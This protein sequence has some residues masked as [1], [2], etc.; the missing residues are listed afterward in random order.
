VLGLTTDT[1]SSG[2]PDCGANWMSSLKQLNKSAAQNVDQV[3]IISWNDYDAG[4]QIE[5]GV[6]GCVAIT[7]M[8]TD[9][10]VAWNSAGN[11]ETIDHYTIYASTDGV[12]FTAVGDAA[13]TA[14]GFDLSALNTTDTQATVVVQ[15]VGKSSF[16]NKT[17]SPVTYNPNSR[18][19]APQ[20]SVSPSSGTYP[21]TVS[22]TVST[23]RAASSTFIDFGDGTTANTASASHTYKK[24]G[25]FT[26]TGTVTDTTGYTSSSTK[27]V[28][29]SAP[30]ANQAPEAKLAVTPTSGTAPL[31]VTAST[32]GS[33]DPDGTIASVVI[34][35][36]D[37]TRSN[38]AS[39]SHTYST[40]G[41]YTVIATV[42][43]NGGLSASA[44]ST[45]TAAAP[46]NQAP[47]AKLSV[48]PTTGTAPLAVT[49]STAGSSDPDGTIASVVIDFGDG[50][51][52]NTASASHTYSAAGTFTIT[53]TVTD[54]GGL[55]AAATS[56]V[57]AAAPANQAPVAKLAVTPTSG[58]APLAVTASTSG[59]S[60]PDGTIASVVIDFGDGTKANTASASH[61]YSTAGTYTVKA[62][63]TDNGGLSASA[64]S[65]VVASAPPVNQAPVA[66][67]AVTP[68]SGTAP[69]AVTASTSGSSDPDGTIASV[70][71]DFGDGTK[72]NSASAS[73]TYSAAGTYTVTATVTDN[74]GLSSNASTVVTATGSVPSL[75]ISVTPS[76]GTGYS[77]EYVYPGATRSFF[78]RVTGSSN[79]LVNWTASCGTPSSS[80]GA[81][82]F[83]WTAPSTAGD[84]T[85]TAT[86][87]A[88]GSKVAS[89]TVT[90]MSE[91]IS[92][93]IMPFYLVLYKGQ[94]SDL[95]SMVS[96]ASTANSDVTW[97]I[98][99]PS[100][101]TIVGN[102][103]DRDLGWSSTVAG[104]YT[105]KATSTR[106]TSK[107]AT[108]TIIVTGNAMPYQATAN[109]TQPVDCT[110]T[111]SGRCVDIGKSGS[112]YNTIGSWFSAGNTLAAGDTLRIW[113]KGTAYN[114]QLLISGVFSATQ[115]ARICG[116]PD[117]NGNL[118]EIN[119][120]NAS[121]ANPSDA[122]W[123]PGQ[124]TMQQ[125]GLVVVRNTSY[126]PA[127]APQYILIE[128]LK[129]NQAQA[130]DS[131]KAIGTGTIT[132][133]YAGTGATCVRVQ[134][135]YDVVIRGN[136]IAKCGA[137]GI[138]S[139]A[140]TPEG[141]M[142]RRLTIEGNYLHDNATANN[143]SMHNAYIQSDGAVIQFNYFGHA[144]AGSTG[145][146]LK[147][148]S[149]GLYV[150]YN[151][152]LSE[153]RLMDFVEPQ[154]PGNYFYTYV[155]WPYHLSTDPAD[156]TTLGTVASTEE[157]LWNVYSYG[158]TMWTGDG[159]CQNCIHY[160]WD[161]LPS[162]AQGGTLWLY[163]NTIQSA[164]TSSTYGWTLWD[165]GKNDDA[166]PRPTFPHAQ[167]VNNLIYRNPVP[168]SG[169]AP[170]FDWAATT[171]AF[172]TFGKNWIDP[173]WG[174]GNSSP[175]Y[176]H[177]CVKNPTGYTW[178]NVSGLCNIT[179]LDAAHL[180]NGGSQPPVDASTY[181]PTT[182]SGVI[183]TAQALPASISKLPPKFSLSPTTRAIS[184][185]T[186]N[187]DI[188][189]IGQ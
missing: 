189:A 72:A 186:M 83:D 51:K 11:T 187:S 160:G 19:S 95:Q 32:S 85:I 171:G 142:V 53:A 110:C 107:S 12:N 125:Y 121:A 146:T 1:A 31:A 127:T 102:A 154:D 38:S 163:N 141:R 123:S 136:E 66:N 113:N 99:G 20:V 73:H 114:E 45:I 89:S 80:T 150:R 118:P 184:A 112:A 155:W 111:G 166:T 65:T 152:L 58:T 101:G 71:I 124:Y 138:M 162:Q 176:G 60:D 97:T 178:Q 161:M 18:K 119:G 70:V 49:A 47:V 151:H 137:W 122:N 167:I 92:V 61:T 7:P 145:S 34:D 175:D 96:G 158:N 156:T 165:D 50:T 109:G 164:H 67:L 35:F 37:G 56:T 57:T 98:A 75:A 143:Y 93:N 117:A 177:N 6:D 100:Q 78:S 153:Q 54:N 140:Q 81:T 63:V 120:A 149:S 2:T 170:L 13:A 55:S 148:R 106:D 29:A 131:Y 69:L 5:A 25:N 4:K 76:N 90:V 108:A 132:P 159:Y 48:T 169:S 10:G 185:R 9:T 79:A 172:G 179:N 129:I 43:D 40:A 180:I 8:A 21:L 3:Q 23:T 116:V 68:T 46:A 144:V 22:A 86:A 182:G 17:S 147:T 91:S 115:P 44:T 52:A 103:T 33:S 173:N 157:R 134:N 62:T 84:C 77:A 64:T 168:T 104:T 128:G 27:T 14:S 183:G 26:V 82:Y 59:S 94:F 16:I 105:I 174:T 74:G 126:Y 87:Q 88:D 188:G 133:Y 30:P 28:T 42:T 181:A 36:G 24:A 139:N 135:G 41:T 39:A 130:S 15:A